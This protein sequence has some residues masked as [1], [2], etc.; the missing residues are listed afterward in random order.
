MAGDRC[1]GF[2]HPKVKALVESPAARAGAG[3]RLYTS[4]TDPRLQ[5]LRRLMEDEW[6]PQLA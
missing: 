6:T 4:S 3:P 5:R 1:A 2:G